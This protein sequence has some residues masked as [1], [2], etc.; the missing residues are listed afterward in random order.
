MDY[1][2]FFFKKRSLLNSM[3]EA[4]K[5]VKNVYRSEFHTILKRRMYLMQHSEKLYI[6]YLIKCEPSNFG[7][8]STEGKINDFLTKTIN[9]KNL[10]STIA[11]QTMH[12][13]QTIAVAVHTS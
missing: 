7:Y 4:L 2:K 9:F 6:A 3:P 8:T 5:K 13:G 12:T 11:I 10:S 1:R